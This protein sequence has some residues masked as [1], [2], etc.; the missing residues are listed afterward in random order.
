MLQSQHEN[1]SIGKEL[2]MIDTEI[3]YHDHIVTLFVIIGRHSVN[4][5]YN[6]LILVWEKI[7]D[8]SLIKQNQ[9][10]TI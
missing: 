10:I 7:S 6:L 3:Y 9:H 2:I 5:F 8:I 4:Y 1:N